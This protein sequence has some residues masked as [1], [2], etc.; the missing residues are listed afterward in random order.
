[1]ARRPK[2]GLMGSPNYDGA[3]DETCLLNVG[4]E[5]GGTSNTI[6]SINVTQSSS[7][8]TPVIV[9]GGMNFITVPN[10]RATIGSQNRMGAPKKT[11]GKG[12]S[13]K[14]DHSSHWKP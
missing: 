4:F 3:G 13:H 9:R 7:A 8:R 11:G 14:V 5:I 1:M 10:L 2:N 12:G 6:S